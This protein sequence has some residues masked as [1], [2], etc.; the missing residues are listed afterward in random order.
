MRCLKPLVLAAA[1]ITPLGALAQQDDRDFLTA[2]LEDN[3]S[4]AGRDV[5]I[6]GFAGALSS[7]ATVQ[8][9]TIADAEGIWITLQGVTL[10]WSRSALLSGA[11]EINALTADKILIDRLP[12][13]DDSALPDP[14]ARGF[15]L[16]ELPVSVRIGQLAATRIV[17]GPTVLGQ[18]VEGSLAASLSLSSGE[19]RAQL[20][21]TRTDDGPAGSA[22]RRRSRPHPRLPT[23]PGP[24]DGWH[25]HSLRPA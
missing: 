8:Q 5:T 1:L 22:I 9:M 15:S 14:E 16:P 25:W 2:F 13:A 17:L 20:D 12:V 7:R 18:D 21:L 11:V 23:G 10:D 4:D 24:V 3:L 6:T 19:G